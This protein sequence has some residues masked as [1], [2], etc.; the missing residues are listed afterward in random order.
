MVAKEGDGRLKLSQ[1]G[2]RADFSEIQSRLRRPRPEKFCQLNRS[3]QHHNERKPSDFRPL[4]LGL[5]SVPS[6]A[7]L[8]HL[9]RGVL[10]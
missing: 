9:L 5:L 7:F 6:S 8:Q 10:R 1:V 2:G 3:M 4:K